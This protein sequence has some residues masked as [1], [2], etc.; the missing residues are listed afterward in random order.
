[1]NRIASMKIL[2]SV[3]TAIVLL[4]SAEA[5]YI[6][7]ETTARLDNK[8]GSDDSAL[9]SQLKY[10]LRSLFAKNIQLLRSV[11]EGAI[12]RC[13]TTT[14][15]PTAGTNTPVAN[16]TP[17]PTST[18]WDQVGSDVNGAVDQLLGEVVSLDE[19][20]DIMI[21]S[22]FQLVKVY[23]S[24][25]DDWRV[26][27]WKELQDLS[28]AFTGNYLSISMA[29]GGKY[30]IVGDPETDA[31]AAHI[32]EYKESVWTLKST[33]KGVNTGDKFGYSVGIVED[34]QRLVVGAP[35]GDYAKLIDL[36][37]EDGSVFWTLVL[38]GYSNNF[39]ISLAISIDG[40]RLAIGAYNDLA[41]VGSVYVYE[42]ATFYVIQRFDGN[43]RTRGNGYSFGH[44]VAMNIDGSI[45]AI[46]TFIEDTIQL[47]RYNTA[48]NQYDEVG[49]EIAGPALSN[50]GRSVSLSGTGN[51]VAIGS[52]NYDVGDA[53]PSVTGKAQVFSVEKSSWTY[54]GGFVGEALEDEFGSAVAFS[55][56]GQRVAIGGIKNTG[57][58]DDAGHVRVFSLLP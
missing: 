22:G 40:Q 27:S 16:P 56:D 2:T 48:R 50:F 10:H 29:K 13:E 20:G 7:G 36:L 21:I 6:G 31:G 57:G 25:V 11:S 51:R 1:M 44:S 18:L 15:A 46:G 9:S 34:G 45:L 3:V 52:P 43:T 4:S 37:S 49:P 55:G 14:T 39:G 38:D 24:Q 58:G 30:L 33:F 47:L 35:G 28:S 23:K 41:V 32:F 26:R 53:A 54:I 8:D 19:S 12:F 17:S 42:L 5:R